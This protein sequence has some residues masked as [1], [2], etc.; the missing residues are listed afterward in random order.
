MLGVSIGTIRNMVQR[1]QLTPVDLGLQRAFP[2]G[3][4]DR[5][6]GEG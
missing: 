6:M 5:L 3:D 2:P 4:I 1:G